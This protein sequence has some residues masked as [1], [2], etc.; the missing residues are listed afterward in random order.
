MRAVKEP[1]YNPKS[2]NDNRVVLGV[3]A[4]G[5]RTQK[6]IGDQV[7]TLSLAH[8]RSAGQAARCS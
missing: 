6:W 1:S 8:V 7:I 5:S 3:E 4:V 2:K